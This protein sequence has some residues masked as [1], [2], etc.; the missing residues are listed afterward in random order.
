MK[1][2]FKYKEQNKGGSDKLFSL[3]FG[4]TYK[5]MYLLKLIE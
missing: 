3:D 1:G 5:C 4:G 2:G